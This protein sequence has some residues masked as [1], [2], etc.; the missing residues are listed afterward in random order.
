MSQSSA[1]FQGLDPG[2]TEEYTKSRQMRTYAAGYRL[3]PYTDLIDRVSRTI[4]EKKKAYEMQ[5]S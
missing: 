5:R 3:L 1:W 2:K 4:N